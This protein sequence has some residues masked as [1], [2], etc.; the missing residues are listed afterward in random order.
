M[1]E[2]TVVVLGG[3]AAGIFGAIACAQANPK[4]KVF[5][6]EKTQVLLAKVRISG[7]GR[8]N[9]THHCFDVLQLVKNYP[10]G[11]KALLAPFHRFQPRDTVAWFESRGVKLKAEE[12][13]RMFPVTDSSQT[14]IDCLLMQAANA[15]V[16]IQL[17]QR[18]KSIVKDEKGFGLNFEGDGTLHCDRLL[19]ATGSSTKGYEFAKEFG[20]TI[21]PSVPSLFTFNIPSFSL[22]DLSGVS[23]KEAGLKIEGTSLQQQG[24]LLITHWGFSGPA[25][26]KLSAWGAQYLHQCNYRV[27]LIINWF[28]EYNLE[29]LRQIFMERKQA[30]AAQLISSGDTLGM[31][32]N[33]WKRLAE[34]VEIDPSKRWA[35]V[36]KKEIFRWTERLVHDPYQVEGKT[37]YKQE[38][39]TCGGVDLDEINFKTMESRKCPGLYF[40]GEILN[41]D[42]I[43]GGFN[44]QNAWTTAWIA[45]QAMAEC[46]SHF[47]R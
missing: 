19:L 18:V 28:P 3:G 25:A 22:E 4:V 23:V 29:Q 39:V 11:G 31:A 45:G 40:A 14:I 27:K 17:N 7:G 32:R 35:D 30:M 21:I 6:L 36:P 2:S 43:T 34:Q 12:D 16:E 38:F 20:H 10:R 15:G 1:F 24:A 5:L 37:T 33:L 41:I 46:T 47:T 42:G 8:C 26:L 13:G 44:F 9:V